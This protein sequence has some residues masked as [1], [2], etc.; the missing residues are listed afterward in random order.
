MSIP[1]TSLSP[2][3]ELENVSVC[4]RIPEERIGTF[5]EY[6]IRVLQNK[7]RSHDF[8]A[9]QSIC[10][11]VGRGETVGIIG[12]N[13]AGKS[14]L[15]KVVARVLVPS[16]GR[17][18]VAGRV[19][20]LLE[21]GAGFHS[22]LTG[23]ENIFLNGTLLGHSRREIASR[24]DEVLDFAEL[25]GFVDA[26]LRTYSSGMV[27]RLG[28]A[29]ATTWEPEILLLDETLSVGDE[30]FRAKCVERMESFRSKGTTTLVVSHDLGLV[31]SRCDRVALLDQG[32]LQALGSVADIVP[33][34]RKQFLK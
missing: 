25:D 20:P 10:L 24:L 29:I 4:Y 9:L 26:P 18:R 34:Y 17:V 27:A 6:A 30:G 21:L 13:G 32:R 22:E 1:S 16:Q 12:A 33:L 15:L 31:E 7:V 5:K 11:S 8:L 19:S 28:F 23:R 14:T 3:I 2:D